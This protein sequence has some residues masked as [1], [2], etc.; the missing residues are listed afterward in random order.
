[1]QILITDSSNGRLSQ[2]KAGW[3]IISLVTLAVT[4]L[5]GT[6]GYVG[7]YLGTRGSEQEVE[8]KNLAQEQLFTSQS[9]TLS[10]E[11]DEQ[12][13][14]INTAVYEAQENLNALAMKLGGI[15]AKVTRL[16]AASIRLTSLAGVKTG[17]FNYEESPAIGGI[18]DPVNQREFSVP[19]FIQSLENLSDKVDVHKHKL[20]MLESIILVGQLEN[21]SVP[22]GNPVADGWISSGFGERTDPL[23]G[24]HDLHRG[25][26]F[27]GQEGTHIYAVADG[28]VTWSGKQTGFGNVVEIDHGY[29]YVTRYAHN[30]ENIV[31]VG[32]KVIKGNTIALMGSTGRSTGTHVHF[33]VEHNGKLVNPRHYLKP[34]G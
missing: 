32:D 5:I 11:A 18:L 15:Q 10:E 14:Q 34:Q 2:L 16:E 4:C 19:D 9:L 28:V 25:L 7:Y 8:L 6:A 17:E 3:I 31:S 24:K 21:A 12:K 20:N 27:A 23:S 13:L 1:M 30:K 33:E 26:D 29:G 22:S